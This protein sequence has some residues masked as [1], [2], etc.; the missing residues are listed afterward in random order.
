MRPIR[1]EMNAF[2]SYAEKT[3]IDFSKMQ[4][5][6][7]LI[8]GDTGAGKT[9][10]FDAITYALY[11]QTSGGK[12][13]GNMMRSHYAD[14]ES[15]T[16]V[17]LEF[18]YRNEIYKIRRNPEYL[19]LGK[20]KYADGSNRYVKETAKVE[21][22]LPDGN[23]FTGKKK[24]TDAK[25]VEIMGV[26]ADQ[27]TQ[28][29][30]IA[31][32]DFLK[33]LHAESKERRKI[34]SR[35]F[36]TR[37]YFLVQERLKK[38]A[39]DL[40]YQLQNGI[41][42]TKKEMD[43]VELPDDKGIVARWK[44]IMKQEVTSYEET[45][46]LLKII[47]R[48]FEEQGKQVSDAYENKQKQLDTLNE[49]IQKAIVTN[50]IFESL[51]LA[52]KKAVELQKEMVVIDEKRQVLTRI[53]KAEK[54]IPELENVKAAKEL[55]EKSQEILNIINVRKEQLE[56]QVVFKEK[57]W[58]NALQELEEKEPVLLERITK[59]KTTFDQY[60]QAEKLS[61]EIQKKSSV[62]KKLEKELENCQKQQK[63]IKE[64]Q[65]KI[66]WSIL[67][68]KLDELKEE[69]NQC[70]LQHKKMEE[71]RKIYQEASSEYE[72]KYM[73]FLDEKA[74]ILAYKLKDDEPCPVCGSRIHP[75]KAKI[76]EEVVSQQ[77]VED[78]K[79]IRDQ[80]E[81]ARD[82]QV[83]V[84]QKALKSQ[85]HCLGDFKEKLSKYTNIKLNE[86][87]ND[88]S[89]NGI[90]YK[91]INTYFIDIDFS[92]KYKG[93]ISEEQ[94]DVLDVIEQEE[95]KKEEDLKVSIQRETEIYGN[96]YTEHKTRVE[97]LFY[98][99]K[100]EAVE[101]TEELEN[102]LLSLKKK[103]IL[104][105]NQY[106]KIINE[107]E[108]LSGQKV[109]EETALRE[110]KGRMEAEEKRLETSL[111]I[112]GFNREELKVLL[113]KQNNV[114]EYE[115]EI[116]EY[117]RKVQENAGRLKEL[118]KQTE[119]ASYTEIKELTEE[120]FLLEKVLKQIQEKK[121]IL[122]SIQ[123]K[124]TEI[125]DYL[126]CNYL[127]RKEIQKKYEIISNLSRTANGNLSGSV[128]MDFETYVQR[129]YFRKI[130]YA[131]NKRLVKMTK[132][133]F[134]L[135]CRDM[136]NLSNQGQT[137][138]D[139]D[140]YHM[141]TDSARDVKTLSGGESFMASLSMALGLSDIVQN[142]AGGIRLDTMF[143]DE[144]F[145]SLDDASREQAIKVLNELAG[146][147]RLVGIISHVNEL[148]E[149]IETKIIVTRTE[150]G[151]NIKMGSAN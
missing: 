57:E 104:L 18:C 68:N 97:T 150:N 133:E 110:H 45:V 142:A 86:K 111:K 119:G 141:L 130:I 20:R 3:V 43:R 17:E 128:K 63:E 107:L 109:Q 84:Y 47:F 143:V 34:F 49:I 135:Q 76:S 4:N 35:I 27:F 140:V 82:K 136:K 16:Y 92:E 42:D 101:K 139:L 13:D 121:L 95:I 120:K 102:E 9:T 30:M 114:P 11:G 98:Q 19:R 123:K 83:D 56:G 79:N 1:L 52:E 116:T 32:G 40:Y 134:I 89:R 117:E 113:K 59:L 127:K 125:K 91:N 51:I 12:R 53:R 69:T 2:G 147:E 129:Q 22:T 72:R 5:G 64:K 99:T 66:K 106:Q 7:F 62:L 78:A 93:E 37:Y 26:D 61:Q 21:L 96:L 36:H 55:T 138:L 38:Q 31:Q 145:G 132:G 65:K 126:E 80:Y 100:K 115:R 85:A 112:H 23:V 146:N 41:E 144:G 105:Q 131:A 137:G 14:E 24:E 118:K 67:I 122:F 81:N 124:N 73:V 90:V 15:E 103:T 44:E 33:L 25:I 60:E 50:H 10:I 39:S 77:D 94:L 46:E 58:K 87:E 75:E 29:S 6:L 70:F 8:T 148:K 88:Y 74:G 108:R 71:L 151:S 48:C 28:I 149:Q 54:L